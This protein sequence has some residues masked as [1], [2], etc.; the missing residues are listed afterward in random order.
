MK[1]K[2]SKRLRETDMKI[3]LH[4]DEKTKDQ[5]TTLESAGVPGFYV[6]DNPQEIRIQMY[7]L[8]FI[9]RL[10]EIKFET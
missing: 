8:E 9:L 4:L 2:H 7:L 5:Q 1:V 6:T 3:V 10:S